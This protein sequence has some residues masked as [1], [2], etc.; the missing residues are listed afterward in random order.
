MPYIGRNPI[1]VGTIFAFV[2]LNL[3]VVYAKNFSMLLAFRFLT[4]LV[5]S[6]AL[7]TGGASLA[8]MYESRKQIYGL[9]VWGIAAVFGAVD[10]LLE[11]LRQSQKDGSGQ[12]GSSCGYQVS[13]Q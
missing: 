2:L 9:G 4:G 12:S 6:P 8:D 11:G 7:A 1:Y 3:G 13:V 10:L 5:G